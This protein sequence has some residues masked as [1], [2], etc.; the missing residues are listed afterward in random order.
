MVSA[1]A[2]VWHLLPSRAPI[3]PVVG[4]AGLKP[5]F[6]AS[7]AAELFDYSTY[8][9][10]LARSRSPFSLKAAGVKTEWR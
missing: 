9:L 3:K 10:E 4:G 1:V 6:A 8:P 7:D 5:G 2:A